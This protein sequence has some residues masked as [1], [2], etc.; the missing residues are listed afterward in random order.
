MTPV[1]IAAQKNHV[2]ALELLIKANADVNKA[3]QVRKRALQTT[4]IPSPVSPSH[5]SYRRMVRLPF[6]SLLSAATRRRCLFSGTLALT[7]VAVNEFVFQASHGI[8][9]FDRH[10]RHR[11]VAPLG[12]RMGRPR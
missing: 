11:V 2:A 5:L 4:P 8:T 1:Y 12:R 10:A 6:S 7:L 3:N 9:L